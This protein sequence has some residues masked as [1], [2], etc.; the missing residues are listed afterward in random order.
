MSGTDVAS[1]QWA[2]PN[3]RARSRAWAE[4]STATTRVP[5]AAAIITAESPTPPHPCTATHSPAATRPCCTTARY[6]VAN[7]QPS[8]AAVA[9]DSSLG[10][11]TRFTSAWSSATYWAKDPQ[12]VKPGW[13]WRS[14]TWWS[15]AAQDGQVPQAQMN[16]TVTRSPARQPVTREPTASTTPA[17]SCP[18]TCGSVMSGS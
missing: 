13:V 11:A 1:R 2:A 16:G 10:S 9:K 15:P 8:E 3:V 5:D 17:S 12:W 14:H 7:R 18:G 6:A 4:T